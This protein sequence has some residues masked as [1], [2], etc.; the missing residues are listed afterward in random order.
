M[1]RATVTQNRSD[2]VVVRIGSDRSRVVMFGVALAAFVALGFLPAW[3]SGFELLWLSTAA[4][5]MPTLVLFLV[6]AARGSERTL[7]R[8]HNRLLL[9]GEPLDM[10]RVE[11]RV[12]KW[13]FTSVPN[14]YA[15]S[16]WVMTAS[17]PE[18]VPIAQ[19]PTMLE[20][21]SL[22]GTLEE[23]VQRANIRSTVTFR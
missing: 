4:V 22:S 1:R 16:L 3:G 12:L 21:T 5:I 13:P 18:D 17:G 2:C 23:F 19:F 11:L 6:R 14:G 20:A 8:T 7:V 10:A 15:L 9:D